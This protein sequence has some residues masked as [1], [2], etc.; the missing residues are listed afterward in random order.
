M[1]L[2]K[3]HMVHATNRPK[4]LHIVLWIAQIILGAIFLLAGFMKT[5]STI[6][7]L[8][9]SLPWA[10]EVPEGVVRFIGIAELLGGI[11]LLLPSIL[12]SKP[13]LTTWAAIGLVLVM[14]CAI[15]F[16][17]SRGEMNVIGINISLMLIAFLI[18]WGR[19]KKAPLAA[20]S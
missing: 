20:K 5:S 14:L 11:G 19:Y 1:S 2:Q 17:I 9:A 15:V 12:R 3:N 16:H 10:A 7:E 6:N 18:A 8:S 13:V 4:V